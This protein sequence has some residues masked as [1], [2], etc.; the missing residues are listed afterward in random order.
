[1]MFFM[2]VMINVFKYTMIGRGDNERAAHAN[3][4]MQ[5]LMTGET[6][7]NGN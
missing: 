6:K 3:L 5:I 1:M 7:L 4:I 2:N